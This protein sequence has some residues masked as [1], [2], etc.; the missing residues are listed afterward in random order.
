M[1]QNP[2]SQKVKI[3][4]FSA[5]ILIAV[6]ILLRTINYLCIFDSEILYFSNHPLHTI[7]QTLTVLTV[8]WLLTMLIF[9]PRYSFSTKTSVTHSIFS[10]CLALFCGLVVFASFF[11]FRN[12][13]NYYVGHVKFYRM[14]VLFTIPC[15][16]YFLMHFSEKASKAVRSLCGYAALIWMGLLLSVTYLNLFVTMNSPFKVTLH[17]ALIALMLHILED[18]RA[19]VGRSFRI[20][21][22][23][24]TLIA[25]LLCG[26]ASFPV[27]IGYLTE[28]HYDVDYLFYALLML[29]FFLYLC[30]R[31]RDSYH[32][33]MTTQP[34]TPEEIEEEA[35]ARE[36]KNKKKTPENEQNNKGDDIH[37]S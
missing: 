23:A 19:S 31:A 11:F 14:L 2:A 16:A 18:I 25:I 24:Y 20:H 35:R 30:A 37:V 29:G 1:S 8:L 7:Y 36:A 9:I 21:G 27:I 17:L 22:Y 13:I 12:C 6:A 5:V 15:A 34:A 28:R 4:T 26:V 33:L 10:R 3:Y 32:V